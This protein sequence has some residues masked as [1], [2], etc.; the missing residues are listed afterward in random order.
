M[1]SVRSNILG[2]GASNFKISRSR[3]KIHDLLDFDIWRL[4]AAEV[5]DFEDWRFGY[6]EGTRF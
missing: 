2:F 5:S 4:Q 1:V 6:L 3:K